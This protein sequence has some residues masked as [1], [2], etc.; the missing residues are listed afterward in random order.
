[1]SQRFTGIDSNAASV[2]FVSSGNHTACGWIYLVSAGGGLD[3]VY[4]DINSGTQNS[5]SLFLGVNAAAQWEFNQDAGPYVY[6]QAA[7]LNT[8]THLALTYDGTNCRSYIN[9]ALV[10][11]GAFSAAGRA[12]F[13]WWDI[14]YGGDF[15]AQDC[16]V[17]SSA[18][19]L[20]QVQTVMLVSRPPAGTAA[21]AWWPMMNDTPLTDASGNGHA[22]SNGGNA[23]GTTWAPTGRMRS[24]RSA[25]VNY[26]AA[27][28]AV[29]GVRRSGGA[30]A[31]ASGAGGDVRAGRASA[32][33]FGV[34]G[35]VRS[36]AAAASGAGLGGDVRG[37]SSIAGAAARGG[38][39]R[40]GSSAGSAAAS[41]GTVR[42][43]L[44]MVGV[45]AMGGTVRGGLAIPTNV[46]P[47]APA[48]TGA[49]LTARRQMFVQT[50]RI[51]RR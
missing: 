41:G 33:S 30:S 45:V 51:A 43:G 22:L 8:W 20:Q 25:H 19:T 4:G 50:R 29:G 38:D 34:G 24:Q 21:Y 37:G 17:F 6:T 40:A 3:L 49:T 14:G 5:S 16:M 15:T 9:G 46:G 1:M 48:G 31:A 39:V 18:L 7:T 2:N 23:N 12:N 47:V 32:G 10:N 26:L 11:T 42:G 27:A 28:S 35:D 36:G 13:N 44:A